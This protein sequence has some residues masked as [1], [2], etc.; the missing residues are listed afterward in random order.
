[1]SQLIPETTVFQNLGRGSLSLSH[2]AYLL[3]SWRGGIRGR[4]TCDVQWAGATAGRRRPSYP[5]REE[6]ITMPF[7]AAGLGR[8]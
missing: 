1:M 6:L 7:G 5:V 8:R 2:Q 3:A 4:R